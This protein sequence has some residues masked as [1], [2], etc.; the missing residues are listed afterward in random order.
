MGRRPGGGRW[1]ADEPARGRVLAGATG[2]TD[3]PRSL[4]IFA[5]QLS[6]TAQVT[7]AGRLTYAGAAGEPKLAPLRRASVGLSAI[8]VHGLSKLG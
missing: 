4:R 7:D 5:G 8:A 3:S 6:E 1:L 2:V